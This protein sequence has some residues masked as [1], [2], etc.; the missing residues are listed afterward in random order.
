MHLWKL[1]HRLFVGPNEQLFSY[2]VSDWRE[3]WKQSLPLRNH[4]RTLAVLSKGITNILFN[5]ALIHRVTSLQKMPPTAVFLCSGRLM[6]RIIKLPSLPTFI[7]LSCLVVV[8]FASDESTA[9]DDTTTTANAFPSLQALVIEHWGI[10][11]YFYR[12]TIDA[13][14]KVQQHGSSITF[15]IPPPETGNL[16]LT[17]FDISTSTYYFTFGPS[18]PI[19]ACLLY[20]V[21]VGGSGSSKQILSG[22]A[23]YIRGMFV[24]D[25]VLY[26]YQQVLGDPNP[27]LY[28]I[29]A[30]HSA[31]GQ[32]LY[33]SHSHTSTAIITHHSWLISYTRVAWYLARL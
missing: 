27:S 19:S 20:A 31:S 29:L 16:Y 10:W 1:H 14:G 25:G 24:Q 18:A 15:T 23:Q 28:E 9:R 8:T 6:A 32:G 11:D 5:C 7:V 3:T 26:I 17:A 21:Q 12:G 30:Y 33:S 2:K 13:N 4:D 22:V